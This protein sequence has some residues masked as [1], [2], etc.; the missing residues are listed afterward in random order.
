MTSREEA[1][2]G[3]C[4]SSVPYK[5]RLNPQERAEIS[6][7]AK[8]RTPLGTKGSNLGEVDRRLWDYL[9]WKALIQT[10]LERSGLPVEVTPKRRKPEF[11]PCF[12]PSAPMPDLFICVLTVCLDLAF[13][14]LDCEGVIDITH[15]EYGANMP[16][17]LC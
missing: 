1:V 4:L 12:G 10:H 3:A 13:S 5:G 9:E 6:A 11:F 14:V 2:L 16:N 17:Q 7:Q 8:L 15:S